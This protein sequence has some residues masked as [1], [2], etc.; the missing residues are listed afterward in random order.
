M[1]LDGLGDSL[2]IRAGRRRFDNNGLGYFTRGVIG[3]SNDSTI[4]NIGVRKEMSLELGG[5]NL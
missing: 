5:R 4:R 3:D 1:F 2:V